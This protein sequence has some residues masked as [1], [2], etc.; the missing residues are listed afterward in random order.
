[1]NLCFVI[2]MSIYF[3]A[4]L[5]FQSVYESQID[6]CQFS[7]MNLFFTKRVSPIN[8]YTYS[9]KMIQIVQFWTLRL[10][11]QM[12]LMF[13]RFRELNR[14]E[15]HSIDNA[16]KWGFIGLFRNLKKK[17]NSYIDIF[18]NCNVLIVRTDSCFLYSNCSKCDIIFMLWKQKK[19]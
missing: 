9:L 15:K 16:R 13:Q 7:S 19:D 17:S 18:L 12:I 3:F 11:H 10:H 1:M 8:Y 4:C 2:I 5:P 14:V 6:Q